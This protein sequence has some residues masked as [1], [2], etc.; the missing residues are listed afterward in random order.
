MQASRFG[1]TLWFYQNSY[2]SNECFPQWFQLFAGHNGAENCF[3][4]RSWRI[5]LPCKEK[6]NFKNLFYCITQTFRLVKTS[7]NCSICPNYTQKAVPRVWVELCTQKFKLYE[8]SSCVMMSNSAFFS[9]V[10]FIPSCQI[11]KDFTVYRFIIKVWVCLFNIYCYIHTNASLVF[12]F[13]FFLTYLK[14]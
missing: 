2:P 7:Q 1:A 8:M 12:V 6:S 5:L 13:W 4:S 14:S 10:L 3:L 11:L 9:A